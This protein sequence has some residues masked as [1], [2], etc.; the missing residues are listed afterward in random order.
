MRVFKVK[1]VKQGAHFHVTYWSSTA[2]DHTFAK[3][4]DLVM[5]EE[6]WTELVQTSDD[7]RVMW[8]QVGA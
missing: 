7:E 2:W 1:A 6:D 8:L 4:G 5:D 3:L